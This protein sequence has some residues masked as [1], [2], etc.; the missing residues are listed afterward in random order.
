[1]SAYEYRIGDHKVTVARSP[2]TAGTWYGWLDTDNLPSMVEGAT[3]REV[4]AKMMARLAGE[5]N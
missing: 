4:L 2:V 5:G 3:R 1:M